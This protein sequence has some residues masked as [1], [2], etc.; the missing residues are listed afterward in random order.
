M[1][2]LGKSVTVDAF[3]PGQNFIYQVLNGQLVKFDLETNGYTGD[4]DARGC[5][6]QRNWIL[7]RI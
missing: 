4:R 2:F 5:E 7:Q 3:A 1:T 6:C